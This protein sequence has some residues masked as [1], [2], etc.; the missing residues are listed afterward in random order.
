MLLYRA[1]VKIHGLLNL[2]C[3]EQLASKYIYDYHAKH[4]ILAYMFSCT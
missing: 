1:K 4:C 3:Y 2:F